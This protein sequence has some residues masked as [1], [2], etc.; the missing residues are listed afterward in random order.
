MAHLTSQEKLLIEQNRLGDSLSIVREALRNAE[1]VDHP[2]DDSDADDANEPG[3]PRLFVAAISKLFYILSGSDVSLTLASRTGRDALVSDLTAVR[4]RVQKGDIDHKLFRPLS[5]LVINQAP[6]AEIWATVISVILSST[7]TTPPPSL[8]S[9][10]D[11]PIT[12]S[13]ASQQGSEQTRRRI[14]PRVFEEIKHCTYRAV[15]GFHEKYFEGRPWSRRAKRVYKASQ[16]Y[17]DNG[18]KRWK[19]EGATEEAICDWWLRF[20]SELLDKEK[21]SYFR[22]SG[23]KRVGGEAQRQLDLL[24]K[25]NSTSGD[26]HDW[27]DV[28]VIGELKEADK[29]NKTLWL[30]VGSAVRHVFAHQPTRRFV[31]AFTL[32]GTEMETWVFDRSGPF[33]GTA[34]DIHDEPEKFIQVL[35]GYLMMSDEEL[36]NDTFTK[37]KN[38]KLFVTI[39]TETGGKTRKRKFELDP[40]PIALQRA[41]VCR[42]TSCFL[43]KTAGTDEFDTVMKF[44]WTSSLRKPEADLLIK[45]SE[46]GVKGIARVVGYQEEITTIQN[47]RTSLTFAN[48]HKFRNPPY[49][50]STSFSQ[51]QPPASQSFGQFYGLSIVSG[52]SRKRRSVDSAS[53]VSKR[54]RSGSQL[55]GK[56][57]DGSTT[58]AVSKPEGTSLNG[59]QPQPFD[60]RVLRALAISPAGRSISQ[61]T[62][63]LELI[64]AL[65]DAIT[66]HRSLLTDG[67]IL[68]RDISENNIIITDPEKADGFRG[69]LIDLDLAKEDGKGPSGARYRT[70]TMEFM[71]IEV[72][73]GVSHTYRHDL[74][75]FFYVLLWL[76]SRRGWALTDT[77][78]K[79]RSILSHWYTGTYGDIARGKRGDMIKKG[80]E[81]LLQQFPPSFEVVKPL[82]R[83]LRG[84]LFP[85]CD[86]DLFTG[87][88][89]D[90]ENLYGPIMKAFDDGL[91]EIQS[92][93]SP[94]PLPKRQS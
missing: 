72:L 33:S 38:N 61:F 53:H 57:D 31:H 13:S 44:S 59:Q 11:T 66:V 1:F 28:L 26:K 52:A 25:A 71:A 89:L 8:P 19:I 62:S 12:H 79:H 20:Q 18:K 30:Q 74:E 94:A 73:L 6:D 10:F 55:A 92:D 34:F 84:I 56:C 82:C 37:R 27:K 87:T 7:H 67:K 9:S 29:K 15:E 40:V 23:K 54:S 83:R 32:T 24:V 78:P 5:Q 91:K 58:Y 2:T 49:S 21:A 68:H 17:Y 60:N 86:G 93:N 42:G 50:N 90:P 80:L 36:G 22:S 35:C 77:K 4:L 39:P 3:R 47:L 81:D 63:V 16:H 65:R 14:E 76:C 64:E 41:I 43:A 88:P 70:G 75:A 85:M 45:A 69:M 51:S 48:P 46:R